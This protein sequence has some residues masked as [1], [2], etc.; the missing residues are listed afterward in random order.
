SEGRRWL[1]CR[2][3]CCRTRCIG[4]TSGCPATI[5]VGGA[6]GERAPSPWPRQST[7]PPTGSTPAIARTGHLLAVRGGGDR[8]ATDNFVI[9]VSTGDGRFSIAGNAVADTVYVANFAGSG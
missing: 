4:R 3:R 1:H 5:A 9:S 6:H 2:W 7:W 8:R